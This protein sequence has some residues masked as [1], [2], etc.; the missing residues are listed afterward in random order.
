MC[1]IYTPKTLYIF[2]HRSIQGRAYAY[3]FKHEIRFD[4]ASQCRSSFAKGRNGGY[5]DLA[6]GN[7]LLASPPVRTGRRGTLGGVARGLF[8]LD[9]GVVPKQPSFTGVVT[10]A[11]RIRPGVPC[12]AWTE[13]LSAVVVR[14]G[15]GEHDFK[16]QDTDDR[17]ARRAETHSE[18][19]QRHGA[20]RRM[21]HSTSLL[22]RQHLP[23]SGHARR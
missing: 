16:R 15:G 12:K 10:D 22:S 14:G 21:A 5:H 8:E 20:S 4:I 1:C 2:S 18:R 9:V 11:P 19:V 13:D 7:R 6:D 3:K 23:L 17:H